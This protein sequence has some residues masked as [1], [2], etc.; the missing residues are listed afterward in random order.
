[1]KF[2]DHD[3]VTDSV[4][5]MKKK[6]MRLYNQELKGGSTSKSNLNLGITKEDIAKELGKIM[7]KYK[8][9]A[10]VIREIFRKDILFEFYRIERKGDTG[11]RCF[12]RTSHGKVIRICRTA[13]RRSE[14][15]INMG[16]VGSAGNVSFQQ[17]DI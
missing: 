8:L 15:S 7:H 1:M 5:E 17:Y 14:T 11:E 16:F 12:Q 6:C 13:R 3:K 10:W 4:Y 2:E 9:K